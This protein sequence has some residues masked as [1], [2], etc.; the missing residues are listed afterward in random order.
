MTSRQRV[1]FQ[2]GVVSGVINNTSQTT[3]TGT[4]WPV[5]NGGYTIAVTLNPG[6]FGVA[7]SQEIV[8]VTGV[9]SVSGGTNNVATVL[10]AQEGTS[11]IGTSSGANY[12]WVAG[13][14]ASDFDVSNLTS[15]GPLTLNHGI[16]GALN[17]Y[18]NTVVSGSL[19]SSSFSTITASGSNQGTASL[20][21]TQFTQVSGGVTATTNSGAGT[22]VLLP[23]ITI[24]GQKILI[25]NASSNWLLLYPATGQSIDGA[26]TNSPVWLAPNAY[27]QGVAEGSTNW[28]SFIP[29]SNSDSTN[30]INVTYGNGQVLYGIN[31]NSSLTTSGLTVPSGGV[32]TASG[33]T[34]SGIPSARIGATAPTIIAQ[35]GGYAT[36][37]NMSTGGGIGY[38]RGGFT[39]D[40][41]TSLITPIAG[42][43]QINASAGFVNNGLDVSL[44]GIYGLS[45]G[46]TFASPTHA[47]AFLLQSGSG[48]PYQQGP[49]T[50]V[51]SD[52][53]YCFAGQSVT[54]VAYNGSESP[55]SQ[56]SVGATAYGLAGYQHTYLSMTYIGS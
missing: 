28:A 40:G 6:Y 23:S 54:L 53:Q 51:F 22:G 21:T 30:T 12:P 47:S 50:I 55:Y 48:G 24:A 38:L 29:S 4:T 44:P 17:I 11:A 20:I 5:P 34:I 2:S 13:P 35:S 25:D 9:S 52:I 31:P 41:S 56:Q 1:N 18:G 49:E 3:I 16:T 32:I 33:V 19:D 27:W 42:Y 45:L 15:T 10:R 43:Y 37:S 8:Y 14:L 46:N 39:T 36:I 26:I 7:G